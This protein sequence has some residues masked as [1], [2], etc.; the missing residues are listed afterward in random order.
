MEYLVRQTT[1][2]KFKT[3][4]KHEF[5]PEQR[6]FLTADETLAQWAMKSLVERVALFKRRYPNAHCTVC[7]LRKLY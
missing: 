6:R 5:T 2:D 4:S 3:T 7:K 1:L